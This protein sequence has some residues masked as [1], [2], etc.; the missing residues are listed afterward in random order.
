MCVQVTNGLEWAGFLDIMTREIHTTQNWCLQGYLPH[1]FVA[2]H[3]NFASHQKTKITFPS[4]HSDLSTRSQRTES[5]LTSLMQQMSP[6]HR[7][8]VGPR[9]LLTD[10]LP[11]LFTILQPNFRAVNTLLYSAKEKAELFA[12][13]NTMLAYN[14]TYSQERAPEGHYTFVMEPNIEEIVKFTDPVSGN[15]RQLGYTA[16]QLVAR[17]VEMEKVRRAEAYFS[18][19]EQEKKL[20]PNR[21]K[22]IASN[23]ISVKSNPVLQNDSATSSSLKESRPLT[24]ET[25]CRSL[26]S[27]PASQPEEEESES[28]VPNHLRKLKAKPVI[29][30]V[31]SKVSVC[32]LRYSSIQ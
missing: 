23:P 30:T 29:K 11:Y 24:N 3:V 7:V 26:E 22:L 12:V 2:L 9:L 6:V 18:L 10:L 31:E 19:Q 13:I 1:V 21:A 16:R 4:Q 32:V 28:N 17:E 5:L 20:I 27:I 15:Q 14:L 8:F 25:V